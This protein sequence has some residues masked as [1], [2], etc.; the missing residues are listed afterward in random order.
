MA[1]TSEH[2]I[3]IQALLDNSKGAG[4][5]NTSFD[6]TGISN[7][8]ESSLNSS[9]K[10]MEATLSNAIAKALASAFPADSKGASKDNTSFSKTL[11]KDIKDAVVDIVNKSANSDSPSNA[12][13]AQKEITSAIKSILTEQIQ[14][15][16]KANK[17]PN[18]KTATTTVVK[19]V[20]S[21]VPKQDTSDIVKVAQ[22]LS[23]ISKSLSSLPELIS[24]LGKERGKDVPDVAKI[25][26]LVEGIITKATTAKESYKAIRTPVSRIDSDKSIGAVDSLA[27]INKSLT[28]TIKLVKDFFDKELVVKVSAD[29]TKADKQIQTLAKDVSTTVDVSVD[30]KKAED[31]LAKLSEQ[32]AITLSIDLEKAAIPEIYSRLTQLQNKINDLNKGGIAIDVDTKAI[33]DLQ[34]SLTRLVRGFD[35]VKGSLGREQYNKQSEL[36][37]LPTRAEAAKLPE[38]NRVGVE[39]RRSNLEKLVADLED[40]RLSM[41]KALDRKESSYITNDRTKKSD[42]LTIEHDFVNLGKVKD[43]QTS[44]ANDN[45]SKYVK[46]DRR[47][48]T[49]NESAGIGELVKQVNGIISKL[50]GITLQDNTKLVE[51]LD[52][53]TTA[54]NQSKLSEAVDKFKTEASKS[55]Y[56]IANASKAVNVKYS[57]RFIQPNV[58]YSAPEKTTNEYELKVYENMSKLATSLDKLQQTIYTKVSEGLK[59][60]PGKRQYTDW[61]VVQNEGT[62]NA[63]NRAFS[64]R[65]R[66]WAMDVVD[67]KKLRSLTGQQEGTPKELLKVYSDKLASNLLKEKGYKPSSLKLELA[68]WLKTNV[69]AGGV[70]G[71]SSDV[72]DVLGKDILAQLNTANIGSASTEDIAAIF[73]KTSRESLKDIFSKTVGFSDIQKALT[74]VKRTIAIPAAK[75]TNTGSTVLETQHGSQRSTLQLAEYKSGHERAFEGYVKNATAMLNRLPKEQQDSFKSAITPEVLQL[76]KAARNI[77]ISTDE[78]DIVPGTT[79]TFEDASRLLLKGAAAKNGVMAS[80]ED[81]AEVYKKALIPVSIEK[82]RI[83]RGTSSEISAK[84]EYV[85]LVKQVDSALSSTKSID[86]FMSTMDSLG[87]SATK[88]IRSLDSLNFSNVYDTIGRATAPKI[89]RIVE[90][91]ATSTG[92]IGDFEKTISSLEGMMPIV[93]QNAPR[94]GMHQGDTVSAMF[95][96]S[97]AHTLAAGTSKILTPEGQSAFADSAFDEEQNFNASNEAKKAFI[98]NFNRRTSELFYEASKLSDLKGLAPDV[99]YRKNLLNVG[100]NKQLTSLGLPESPASNLEATPAAM[101]RAGRTVPMYTGNL[102]EIAPFSLEYQQTGRNI[103][104]ISSAKGFDTGLF[105]KA[106]GISSEFPKLRSESEDKVIQAGRFGS[107][108]IGYNVLA[109]LRHTAGTFED[110]ILVSGKLADAATT[111]VRKLVRPKASSGK[112]SAINEGVIK[113]ADIEEVTGNIMSIMGID[114]KYKRRPDKAFIADVKNEV[115]TNRGASVEVQS[116]KLAELFLNHFGRKLTTRYGSKGVS[117]TPTT[118]NTLGDIL[119][120]NQGANVKVLP[121]EEGKKAGLGVAFMPKSMGELSA[122]ILSGQDADKKA[123]M[124]S[125]LGM[126]VD[127]L[128]KELQESGN[129]FI[130]DIFTDTSRG[131]VTEAEAAK[132]LTVFDKAKKAFAELDIN[133]AQNIKGIEQIRGAHTG[134]KTVAKAI[135]VRI[136][137]YGAAKRGLQTEPLELIANNLASSGSNTVIKN[138]IDDKTSGLISGKSGGLFSKYSKALGFSGA[139]KSDEELQKKISSMFPKEKLQDKN[140]QE[141]IQAMVELEKKSSYYVEVVDELNKRRKSL[142]GEKFLSIVE[143]PTQTEEWSKGAIASLSKGIK[144]NIP[145]YAAYTST[146]GEDSAFMKELNTNYTDKQAEHYDNILTYLVNTNEAYKKKVLDSVKSVD[147]KDLKSVNKDATKTFEEGAPGSLLGTIFDT[148]KLPEAYKTL[149][150]S[151]QGKDM[152]GEELYIPR[153]ISRTAY[154]DPMQAGAY[155]IKKLGSKLQDVIDKSRSLQS[156]YEKDPSLLLDTDVTGMS[157]AFGST[158]AKAMESLFTKDTYGRSTGVEDTSS[159]EAVAR[160]N[161]VKQEL[162]DLLNKLDAKGKLSSDEGSLSKTVKN[163]YNSRFNTSGRFDSTNPSESDFVKHL[164][165]KEGF[166]S[167]TALAAMKNLLIGTGKAGEADTSV[168]AKATDTSTRLDVMTGV[169]GAL[170]NKG[171]IFSYGTGANA[172]EKYSNQVKKRQE[173]LDR[174]KETYQD[175]LRQTLVGKKG[176]VARTFFT[177]NIP[178]VLAKATNAT[179]DKTE[180]LMNFS[181]TLKGINNLDLSKEISQIEQLTSEHAA[182]VSKYKEIGMPVL[183]QH[184]LGISSKLAD[185]LKVEFK[186][187]FNTKTGALYKDKEGNEAPKI[188]Q[189]SLTDLLNYVDELRSMVADGLGGSKQGV[190]N[191][192]NKELAPYVESVR[193]PFTGTSSLK[194]YQAKLVQTKGGIGDDSL[195]VPGTPEM[196]MGAFEEV[197]NSIKDK[198]K[199][200]SSERESAR[201]TGD[202]TRADA[203]TAT[204]DKLNEALSAVLPKYVAH[205]QK[206]DYDGDQLELHTAKTSE[207]RNDIY[208]HF[209]MLTEDIDSTAGKFGDYYAYDAKQPSQ[210]D[211]PLSY[212]SK[213]FSK[214]FDSSKGYSFLD[215]PFTTEDLGYLTQKEKVGILA[216]KEQDLNMTSGGESVSRVMRALYDKAGSKFDDK[217]VKG[218]EDLGTAA[219]AAV[220]ELNKLKDLKLKS[221][222]EGYLKEELSNM[223]L[224]TAV[225]AQL[226]KI[227]TGTD[228]ES[229]TRLLRAYESKMGFGGGEVGLSSKV[230]SGKIDNDFIVRERNTQMNEFFRFAIQKGMDVKHAG[231]RPIAGELVKGV[232]MGKA[233]LEDLLQKLEKNKSYD[234]LKTFKSI[235]EESLRNTFGRFSTKEL[236]EQVVS[237]R[238]PVGNVDAMSRQDLTDV[239]VKNL[240]FEGFL[241]DLQGT[242]EQLAVKGIQANSEKPISAEV[243]FKILSKRYES[244]DGAPP[245][246]IDVSRMVTNVTDPL[247]KFR[248]GGFKV[249]EHFD[250]KFNEG[251]ASIADTFKNQGAYSELVKTFKSINKTD[252]DIPAYAEAKKFVSTTPREDLISGKVSMAPLKELIGSMENTLGLAPISDKRKASILTSPEYVSK[253]SDIPEGAD[254]DTI[255]KISRANDRMGDLEILLARLDRISDISGAR[256]DVL[257]QAAKSISLGVSEDRATIEKASI[258]AAKSSSAVMPSMVIPAAEPVIATTVPTAATP[259]SSYATYRGEE[260]PHPAFSGEEPPST[261]PTTKGPAMPYSGE[262]IRVFL[263]G[264]NSNL[265]F[266]VKLLGQLLESSSL[267]SSANMGSAFKDEESG[268]SNINQTVDKFKTTEEQ[269]KAAAGRAQTLSPVEG[270]GPDAELANLQLLRDASKSLYEARGMDFDNEVKK[271]TQ[272]AQD[273]I[274]GAKERG[275]IDVQEFL[276]YTKN[277]RILNQQDETQG[278]SGKDI[279]NAWRIYKDAVVGYLIRKAEEA[280]KVYESVKG[281]GG[282]E[283]GKAYNRFESAVTAVQRRIMEDTGKRSDIYTANKVWAFPDIAKAAGVYQDPLSIQRKSNRDLGDVTDPDSELL[284]KVFDDITKDLSGKSRGN[285]VAPTEKARNAIKDLTEMNQEM[286][287]MMS[288]GKLLERL[289]PEVAEAWDFSSAAER[290]TRLRSALELFKQFNVSDSPLSVE[291]K[292]L[293]LTIKM[294]KDAEN[295][296]AK[297]DTGS[298][299]NGGGKTAWGETGV[300]AVPKWADPEMQANMH[301]RNIAKLREYYGKSEAEGG[302]KI[303]ERYSYDAKVFDDLGKPLENQRTYFHKLSESVDSAGKTIGIFTAKQDDLS[304]SLAGANR[305]FVGAIERAVKWGVASSLIYGGMDKLKKAVETVAQV[306]TGM[307]NLRMVMPSV[308]TD[309]E[310]IQKSAVQMAKQYGTPT[311]DVVDAMVVYAQQGLSQSEVIDRTNTSILASN[312]TTLKAKDATE[313]LTS[314]MKIFRSEGEKSMRFLDAWSE[315]EAKHAITAGDM[316]EA[317]KKSAAAAATAGITFDQLNGIVAAIGSVTRQ[318]GKEVGTSLRFIMRRLSSEKGPQE[319]A[320]LNVPT[321]TAEGDLR[322]GFDILSDLADKWKELNNAQKLTVA[323]AIGGTRQYNSLLVLMDNWQEALDGVQHSMN[324]QGSASRRNAEIMSTYTKQVEQTKA[325]FLELQLAFGKIAFPAAKFGLQS[326][327]SMAETVSAI[328]TAFKVAGVA[329]LGLFTYLAKG[330]KILE[331]ISNFFSGGTPIVGNL[332]GSIKDELRTASFEVIG[333]GADDTSSKGLKTL[334]AGKV[335]NREQ[336]R[337]L[338]DFESSIGKAAYLLVSAGKAFN[339]TVGGGLQGTGKAGQSVGQSLVRGGSWLSAIVS[340]L[341]GSKYG[342][343]EDLTYKDLAGGAAE[344]FAKSEGFK[345]AFSSVGLKSL[346]KIAAPFVGVASEVTGLGAAA[347]GIFVNEFA[348][349]LGSGGDIFKD[350][351][352]DNAGIVKAIAPMLLTL[353]LLTPAIKALGSEFVKTTKSSQDFADSMYGVI[354]KDETDLAGIRDTKKATGDIQRKLNA[355]AK[356][357]RP[358]V[359]ARQKYLGTYVSPLNALSSIQTD[360]LNLSEKIAKEN[361]SM[362]AGYDKLGNAVL[363]TAS[364]YQTLID[365]FERSKIRDLAAKDS[366]VTARHIEALTKTDGSEKWKSELKDL[367]NEIPVI[368]ELISNQIS[369]A[370]AK[371]LEL[372]TGKLNSLVAKKN[373]SPMSTVYD[374][375]I[376]SL[377]EKLSKVKESFNSTYADFKRSLANIPT[378]GLGKDEIANILGAKELRAGYQLMID[379]EPQYNVKGVKGT[380]TKEDVLGAEVMRRLFPE[381]N[382]LGATKALTLANTETAGISKREGRLL[383]GDLVTFTDDAAKQFNMAGQQAIVKLKETSDG[384]FE[385]VATYFNTKTLKVD[386][387]KFDS[388]MQDLVEAILPT[389]A[390][391]QDMSDRIEALGTFVTGASAGLI[392]IAKKGF[393]ADFNLGERFFSDIATSTIIQGD[394]GFDPAKGFGESTFQKGWADDFDKYYNK[395]LQDYKTSLEQIEKLHLEGL[396]A[397]SLE[398][399][400]GLYESIVKL[401]NIL[402][403]NQIVLQYRAVFADLTKTMEANTRAIEENIAVEKTRSLLAKETSGLLKGRDISLANTDLGKY[404]KSELSSQER[405]L[406]KSPEFSTKAEQLRDLN[407]RKSGVAEQLYTVER[408][409]VALASIRDLA[410]GF[411]SE[412]NPKDFAN[413]TETVAKTGDLGVAELKIDTSNTAENTAKTVEKLDEILDHLSDRDGANAMQSSFMDALD[414]MLP[415]LNITKNERLNEALDRVAAIRNEAVSSGDSETA[416]KANTALDNLTKQLVDRMGIAGAVNKVNSGL[417]GA[418]DFKGEELVQRAFGGLDFKSVASEMKT[419]MKDESSFF[420][421][422]SKQGTPTFDKTVSDI[423]S[424]QEETIAKSKESSSL[425]SS[426]NLAGLSAGF[427]I[428][429]TFN[430]NFSNKKVEDYNKKIEDL[431]ARKDEV[432]LLDYDQQMSDL[433]TARDAEAKKA[434]MYGTMRYAAAGA[435]GSMLLARNLGFS[436]DNIKRLG[437]GGA[438][439]GVYGAAKLNQGM[440]GDDLPQIVKDFGKEVSIFAAAMKDNG[441]FSTLKQGAAASRFKDAS[442]DFMK[443]FAEETLDLKETPSKTGASRESEYNKAYNS[444]SQTKEDIKF[445]TEWKAKEFKRT[446]EN[447]NADLR[448]NTKEAVAEGI[449]G[450]KDKFADLKDYVKNSGQ[451]IMRNAADKMA[452]GEEINLK[453]EV[454]QTYEGAKTKTTAAYEDWR[455]KATSAGEFTGK[456]TDYAKTVSLG[457]LDALVEALKKNTEA[458]N[459]NTSTDGAEGNAFGGYIQKFATG[460]TVKQIVPGPGDKQPSLL[461]AGEEVLTEEQRKKLKPLLDVIKDPTFVRTYASGGWVDRLREFQTTAEVRGA[462]VVDD[463]ATSLGN[464]KFDAEWQYRALANKYGPKASRAFESVKAMGSAGLDTAGTMFDNAKFDAEWKYKEL[465]KRYGSKASRA[466]ESAKATGTAGLDTLGTIFDNAKFDAEW[467]YNELSKRYGSKASRTLEAAKVMGSNGLDTASELFNNAKFDAEWKYNELSKRYGSKASRAF[468][469]AKSIGSAGLDTAGEMLGNAMFDTEWKYKEL[470]KRYGSKAS[471]LLDAA[472]V[473]GGAGLSG[474]KET[475]GKYSTKA[476]S[477]IGLKKIP[478]IGTVVATGLAANRV[479]SGDYLGAGLEMA[480]G[481]AS[482]IPVVGTAA[483][484]LIDGALVGKDYFSKKTPSLDDIKTKKAEISEKLAKVSKNKYSLSALGALGAYMT[485]NDDEEIPEFASGGFI[486]TGLGG[487]AKLLGIGVGTAAVG[488]AAGIAGVYK[489]ATSPAARKAASKTWASSKDAYKSTKRGYENLKTTS[490]ALYNALATGTI[491]AAGGTLLYSGL[492]DN[493]DIYEKYDRTLT[494]HAHGGYTTGMIKGPGTGTSDSIYMDNVPDGSFIVPSKYANSAKEQLELAKGGPAVSNIKVSNGEYFISS[495]DAKSLGEDNLKKLQHGQRIAFANGGA[496]RRFAE[497]GPVSSDS[498]ATITISQDSVNR[499][500]QAIAATTAFTLSKYAAGKTADETRGVDLDNMGS[501]EQSAIYEAILN[502]SEAAQQVYD[503]INKQTLGAPADAEVAT[504]EIS[505]VL[506]TTKEYNKIIDDTATLESNLIAEHEKYNEEIAKLKEEMRKADIAE[507]FLMQIESMNKA[508]ADSNFAEDFKRSLKLGTG[509]FEGFSGPRDLNIETKSVSDL[510]SLELLQLVQKRKEDQR[511]IYGPTDWAEDFKNFTLRVVNSIN[512]E[513]TYN[514]KYRGQN[515]LK[516]YSEL[517]DEKLSLSSRLNAGLQNRSQATD[518]DEY[519]KWNDF[520]QEVGEDLEEVTKKQDGYSVAVK[521]AARKTDEAAKVITRFKDHMA[522][523]ASVRTEALYSLSNRGMGG[524]LRGATND[525]ALIPNSIEELSTTQYAHMQAGVNMQNTMSQYKVDTALYDAQ[526]QGVKTLTESLSKLKVERLQTSD[527]GWVFKDNQPQRIDNE[528]NAQSESLNNARR[529]LEEIG[530]SLEA[531]SLKLSN[532][533]AA[534]DAAKQF[535][536]AITTVKASMYSATMGATQLQ[537]KLDSLYGGSSP[538]APQQID[539]NQRQDFLRN[540]GVMLESGKSNQFDIERAQYMKTLRTP[541]ISNQDWMAARLGLSNIPQKQE[542]YK[543]HEERLRQAQAVRDAI[544]PGQDYQASIAMT[545]TKISE[546][547]AANVYTDEDKTGFSKSR[548]NDRQAVASLD[549]GYKKLNDLLGSIVDRGTPVTEKDFKDIRG[550][551]DTTMEGLG[552]KNKEELKQAASVASSNPV[553]TAIQKQTEILQTLLTEPQLVEALK[554]LR[555][556]KSPTFLESMFKDEKGNFRLPAPT[557]WATGGSIGKIIRGA[558]TGTS[559]DISMSVPAGSY[560]VKAK[561]A[562]AAKNAIN[563]YASGGKVPINVSN[564]E[565]FLTPEEVANIGGTEVAEAFNSGKLP[566]ED[567]IKN[568]WTKADF[569]S[570][571]FADYTDYKQQTGGL[572]KPMFDP[573][574]LLAG[575]GASGLVKNMFSGASKLLSKPV[576]FSINETVT[577]AGLTG[578]LQEAKSIMGTNLDTTRY[579][580]EIMANPKLMGAVMEKGKLTYGKDMSLPQLVT[581]SGPVTMKNIVEHL[582]A[583]QG[584]ANGGYVTA[585]GLSFSDMSDE[586]REKIIYGRAGRLK[587]IAQVVNG[588]EISG[589]SQEEMDRFVY[590]RAGRPNKNLPTITSNNGLSIQVSSPEDLMKIVEQ[591]DSISFPKVAGRSTVDLNSKLT[592]ELKETGNLNNLSQ[593]AVNTLGNVGI[594]SE[595]SNTRLMAHGVPIDEVGEKF[596]S[597]LATEKLRVSKT[598]TDRPANEDLLKQI[599]DI[600]KENKLSGEE[601]RSLYLGKQFVALA[602]ATTPEEIANKKAVLDIVAARQQTVSDDISRYEKAISIPTTQLIAN[603]FDATNTGKS[604]SQPTNRWSDIKGLVAMNASGIGKAFVADSLDK[605]PNMLTDLQKKLNVVS[606]DSPERQAYLAKLNDKERAAFMNSIAIAQRNVNT[607]NSAGGMASVA[608]NQK[609]NFMMA[610]A[611]QHS[612][613]F[614]GFYLQNSD[615]NIAKYVDNKFGAGTFER[616]KSRNTRGLETYNEQINGFTKRAGNDPEFYKKYMQAMSGTT[617]DAKL[618]ELIR[619]LLKEPKGEVITRTGNQNNNSSQV[620]HNGGVAFKS[621][622]YFLEGGEVILDKDYLRDYQMRQSKSISPAQGP[623]TQKVEIEG[624]DNFDKIVKTLEK[625]LDKLTNIK[626]EGIDKLT[627]IKIEGLSD[628]RDIKIEGLSDLKNIKIENVE[629]LKNISIE[630]LSD[631]KDIQVVGLENIRDIKVEGLEQLTNIRIENLDQLKD[632]QVVGLE[633]LRDIKIIGL[634]ELKDI[635]VKQSSVGADMNDMLANT[636]K[637]FDSRVGNL[638]KSSSDQ[639][640]LIK[641]T[642]KDIVAE[643]PVLDINQKSELAGLKKDLMT[644][645]SEVS[646]LASSMKRF[647]Q[648]VAVSLKDLNDRQNTAMTHIYSIKRN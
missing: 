390:I 584:F 332:I 132:N 272:E 423:N 122:E 491:T 355:V 548:E 270:H 45:L 580:K 174:A 11:A 226:F 357:Q 78:R 153:S 1:G 307:A 75:L 565:L 620:R 124:S 137:S 573:I 120:N 201:T 182:N 67:M 367:T 528:I 267:A 578:Y 197:Y 435:S 595:F 639:I 148:D 180:D 141:A 60:Q 581:R 223:K 35:Y 323:Q 206:L 313:A 131:L 236:K 574:D 612:G 362:I 239:L 500:A 9:M 135:D 485:F 606:V 591:G 461:T 636:L 171:S 154:A 93:E 265:V 61:Q 346:G 475:L 549:E 287:D 504:E 247:Y 110:Q 575:F 643:L 79:N 163:F 47:V 327:K 231:E 266:P 294:L 126:N 563:S 280:Q 645:S 536:S 623:A 198:I 414:F 587:G 525:L 331:S 381:A 39:N 119:A 640:S 333:A 176:S 412:I 48:T 489:A 646:S 71:L 446:V 290:I 564:G 348:K 146:F 523:V 275:G 436:E 31:R 474:A 634:D 642:V 209:K 420:G 100:S 417:F 95:N 579:T 614:E 213:A 582:A 111:A 277:A 537:S 187:R 498:G 385:W 343:G 177:R 418:G 430:S 203:L 509:A 218:I 365:T 434:R 625:S 388:N 340:S 398:M 376:K 268:I 65:G 599:T 597:V 454:M 192:I 278:M 102:R 128:A 618:L 510:N 74:D 170:G 431:T 453:D 503:N 566:T 339:D 117:V 494:G 162:L 189:G 577:K 615:A 256:K 482:N 23:T 539:I 561:Y 245:Q 342:K 164:G 72:K 155:G 516:K 369:L 375:D 63:H 315:V 118:P 92:A 526:L 169:A 613:N 592:E 257:P 243:A 36:N 600:A 261:P 486:S 271:L 364:N 55:S 193:F 444:F 422:F 224:D 326:M 238:I 353:G 635:N 2:I 62:G 232:T 497:G 237:S 350:W 99:E 447:P 24:A 32:D 322:G 285:I 380:V 547:I 302:A 56:A 142:V 17:I 28:T 472:Q 562:N 413:Y 125:K 603:Q 149:I 406:I 330:A 571:G 305:G 455:D 409:K 428:Y 641:S 297:F 212:M 94:R 69:K 532:F 144:L 184:E 259:T 98:T 157:G 596:K 359:E 560:I 300:I 253:L 14:G 588:L 304:A 349:K 312:V 156:F 215:K 493:E 400:T 90:N 457:A 54:L 165:T 263:E 108:G 628:L 374:S 282:N 49:L 241:R 86:E 476:A 469:S 490:P 341:G 202:D 130:L 492:E 41:N 383:S 68:D 609:A 220:A 437:A 207:A 473:L 438:A 16:F 22:E 386:E 358:D 522:T 644:T 293:E 590:G 373:A 593:A 610:E 456:A 129:K 570:H 558:G 347:G 6:I 321:I 57:E 244:K 396:D 633:N 291:S 583:T 258:G 354:T 301:K 12:K 147:I 167:P 298:Y 531:D 214:K 273:Y 540:G 229:M 394:K 619:K 378:D 512:P 8:I 601:A 479:A 20:V 607:L 292:N 254:S 338:R 557:D 217:N 372:L 483:S 143:E 204:I 616:R 480:S 344:K 107:S 424:L 335:E 284:K 230:A 499:F 50:G 159:E 160:V 514:N 38:G 605:G 190:E 448:E 443:Q 314:A 228:T 84:D 289:G 631:L 463:W 589:G 76:A 172:D 647:T 389:K 572:E 136:S 42:V 103:S 520:I 617:P 371:S 299:V 363:R 260:P 433:V 66:E 534:T 576:A 211:L 624:L 161:K 138:T 196:D 404:N 279:S 44:L 262:V 210:G 4:S 501:E 441:I 470:S 80:K 604:F 594:D 440:T 337:S 458:V 13:D 134:D 219:E 405:L 295:K 150:P 175:A 140:T 361:Y 185:K 552:G 208:K 471:R 311:T 598:G 58:A 395:P 324:S 133:L 30:T 246:G 462:G 568:T 622:N 382:N 452:R 550:V 158:T 530:K 310:G 3:K 306:E 449:Q 527:R 387:R 487:I 82:Q 495:E 242:I 179:V 329:A 585:S 368:G 524:R 529:K 538:F 200:L 37:K 308:G 328:P 545:S 511:G 464:A 621:G 281:M 89:D 316:A 465:S 360:A 334:I 264:M 460:G 106:H 407:I 116:A 468:E 34:D 569:N 81:A 506:D 139:D 416:M 554:V 123:A 586:D 567:V 234:D 288:N 27:T 432:G 276:N 502:N 18:E 29:T 248:T 425:L 496:V 318:S 83:T 541:G 240:G 630:G 10:S 477:K 283:E 25:T 227:N 319:L 7:A 546:R 427:G 127:D 252:L 222:I 484:L 191:Y 96:F 384:I 186:A 286:V 183:K 445:D 309:F 43:L 553:V 559:D 317:I 637:D 151:T 513:D 415:S 303:G 52:N 46:S 112:A 345:G 543:Q 21:S 166:S 421:L 439:L 517:E 638:E 199:G 556:E 85:N 555:V 251:L 602:H 19:S 478:G 115:T 626:I 26:S 296:L 205:A 225:N 64:L 608:T 233:G 101:N 408:S 152:P 255:A 370:P 33:Q 274:E 221:F 505:K 521:E 250:E 181:E 70:Q 442:E 104:G 168:L 542:E 73:S 533:M 178:S 97:K 51:A 518:E 426:K 411:G 194:P 216:S 114:E 632:I 391:E 648:E 173:D 53:T 195:I 91:I 515:V 401:Q 507:K 145:A 88:V 351:A 392:G 508:I 59:P 105:G 419:V 113:D 467:K 429:Q 377:Q 459:N 481:L 325:A 87:L 450:V 269:R 544:R 451:E 393:K 109:E 629:Y 403:N 356:S 399:S 535:E 77:G 611:F 379:V 40:T 336:G 188:Q 320:K 466:F 249:D 627:D 519:E 5:D 410:S 235:N 402:R 488:T 121:G 366:S 397:G 551:M 352:K 15:F